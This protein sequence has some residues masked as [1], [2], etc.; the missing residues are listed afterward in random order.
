MELTKIELNDGQ[1]RNLP[2]FFRYIFTNDL[3]DID[4]EDRLMFWNKKLK[5]KEMRNAFPIRKFGMLYDYSKIKS[6][7]DDKE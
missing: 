1:I 7:K 3:L 6:S 2:L 4:I 5:H